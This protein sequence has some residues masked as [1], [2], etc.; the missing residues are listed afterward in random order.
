MF[1]FG[2]KKIKDLSDLTNAELLDLMEEFTDRGHKATVLLE[3]RQ[4]ELDILYREAY[5][6][7]GSEL[8]SLA[9]D[10]L[11]KYVNLSEKYGEIVREFVFRLLLVVAEEG[12]GRKDEVLGVYDEIIKYYKE[13]DSLDNVALFEKKKFDY[14]EKIKEYELMQ[15]RYNFEL[16]KEIIPALQRLESLKVNEC[17]Y[18]DYASQDSFDAIW[19]SV[20]HEVDLYEEGEESML[21]KNSCRGAKNWLKSFSHLCKTVKIPE[22][23][24]PKEG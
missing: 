21:N 6:D 24:K 19:R 12:S 2:K 16:K 5:Q 9:L 20:L 4:R 17:R 15:E 7:V 3:E 8:Y 1:G 14:Q 22:E 23:Y 11:N 10:K 13:K 18:D